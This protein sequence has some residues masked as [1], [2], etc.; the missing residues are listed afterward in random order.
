MTRGQCLERSAFD[1][2]TGVNPENCDTLKYRWVVL[3]AAFTIMFFACGISYS[4][5]VILL[6][7][8]NEFHWSRGLAS[9][10]VLFTG[11][12]YCATIPLV[13]ICTDRYG[14][15]WV[16]A[17]TSGFLS[18]GLILTSQIHNLWQLYIFTGLTLGL[19][20]GATYTIPVSIVALWFNKRQGLALGIA[21]MG[22]SLGTALVPFLLA[23]SMAATDWRVTF[24]IGGGIVGILCIT[25]ALLMKR[26]PVNI[27]VTSFGGSA[28]GSIAGNRQPSGITPEKGLAVSEALHTKQ[29]WMF[30]CIFLFFLSSIGLVMVHMVPYAVDS[31]FMPLQAATL[32]TIIGILGIPGRLFSGMLSD[33][34]G[35]KPVIIFCL[36]M[37][38]LIT[39][40][41]TFIQSP[42]AFYIFAALYGLTYS[43]VMNMVVQ[44]TRQTFGTKQLS[45][46][47]ATLMI[48]DGIG[49]GV[50][51]CL[52]GYTFDITG[53]Y[54][55]SFIA[56]AISLLIAIALVIL[57]KPVFK[58]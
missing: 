13:G 34:C 29:F 32:L 8:I 4:Y 11:L 52:A 19:C 22:I 14:F 33:R 36:M 49:F 40:G 30:L 5:G 20:M 44:I 3:A 47:I 48:S 51:P 45:S 2:K 43:G 6:P 35:P 18:L 57:V 56:V 42:W 31:G 9:V 54:S 12:V 10:V 41:I 17:I 7:I 23:F 37:L 16:L 25:S 53:N 24:L 39:G 21:T 15:K 38:A 26:P 58:R 55:L 50:V 1:E 27:N 46:I 28:T